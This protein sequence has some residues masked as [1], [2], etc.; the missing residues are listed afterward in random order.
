MAQREIRLWPDACLKEPCAPV[1]DVAEVEA[2]VGDLFE[3]MYAAPGRG[4][5]APQVGVLARVFVMDAGWK[6]GDMAPLAL[7]NPRILSVSDARM[8]GDEGCLSIPGVTAQVTRAAEVTMAFTD[9]TGAACERRFEGAEAVV[10]QHEYDHLDGLV[11]FDRL[12]PE[13]AQDLLARYEGLR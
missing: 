9:L 3:T 12:S 13:V 6:D 8:T 2:L 11:H 10:A 4:L 7:I 5:A 1:V